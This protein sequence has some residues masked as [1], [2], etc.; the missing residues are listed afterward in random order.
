MVGNVSGRDEYFYMNNSLT[1][2]IDYLVIETVSQE[3][4][5]KHAP[6]K[7][8]CYLPSKKKILIADWLSKS[9]A[10]TVLNHEKEHHAYRT[11]LPWSKEWPAAKHEEMANKTMKR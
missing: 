4:I 8:G 11:E 7:C 9:Q 10:I 3:E 2:D 5:D 1:D 6:G